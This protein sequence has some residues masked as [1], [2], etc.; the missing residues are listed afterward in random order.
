MS[1]KLIALLS[2]KNKALE[3]QVAE[4]VRKEPI[5]REGGRAQP[6]ALT[7]ELGGDKEAVNARMRL[8]NAMRK[9]G[10]GV[11]V[12]LEGISYS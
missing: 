12:K 10:E 4:I 8:Y 2:R 1:V 3:A 5:A 9:A 11:V 7:F 6:R